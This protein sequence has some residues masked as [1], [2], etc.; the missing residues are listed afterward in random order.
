[1]AKSKK[2]PE[3]IITLADGREGVRHFRTDYWYGNRNSRPSQFGRGFPKAEEGSIEGVAKLVMKG[4]ITKGACY[5]R[6]K[7]VYVWSV[8]RGERVAGTKVYQP[9]VTKG[10]PE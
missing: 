7:G 1:M 4:W 5:D 3:K 8:E 10:A 9:I 6:V 2:V